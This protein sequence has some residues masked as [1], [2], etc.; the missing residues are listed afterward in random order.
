MI[1]QSVSAAMLE[2]IP[3]FR[4]FNET[5]RRQIADI[6]QI[7]HFAP[8]DIVV[9]QGKTNQVLWV[10]L[11]GKCEVVKHLDDSP[12][13]SMVLAVLEPYN[14]FGEMSFFSPAPHSA[15]VRAKTAVVA[16]GLDRR[17]YDDLIRQG[18]W[19]AYKL[20]H[21]TVEALA[22]RLRRMD[23]WV[24]DLSS[25]SPASPA[26]SRVPEWSSFREKLFNGWNL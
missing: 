19:A 1:D 10:L 7:R 24:A 20:S 6:S 14:Q 17:D 13:G 26:G 12:Q 23:Q 5:E 8:G 25:H 15:N 22:D 18:I 4:N 2:R 16:L 9:W 21:N 3:L 11:E